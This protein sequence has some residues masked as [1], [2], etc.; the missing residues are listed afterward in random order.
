ML[1]IPTKVFLFWVGFFWVRLVSD[2]KVERLKPSIKNNVKILIITIVTKL[3]F[4]QIKNKQH[5]WIQQKKLSKSDIRYIYII[6]GSISF[7]KLTN[8]PWWLTIPYLE[9]KVSSGGHWCNTFNYSTLQD[10]LNDT[11]IIALEQS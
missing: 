6:T 7:T 10:E 1:R 9:D 5:H 4:I 2:P 8:W 11:K 3:K